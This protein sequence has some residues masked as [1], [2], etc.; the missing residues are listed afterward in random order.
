MAWC[1]PGEHLGDV[2]MKTDLSERLEA[3]QR[4]QRGELMALWRE[5]SGEEPRSGNVAWM[6]KRL[7]WAM[8]AAEYGGLSEAAE[9]RIEELL[10]QAIAWMPIGRATFPRQAAPVSVIERGRLKAGT[11]LTRPYKGKTI[12]VTVREDGF[13]YDGALHGSLS[14]VAKAVT[15]SHW[16][17]RLFFF[18]RERKDDA[19]TA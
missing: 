12:V 16:N 13:E 2:A 10:P 19:R 11:V 9:R 6:R 3:I 7:A 15:G 4:M 1:D 14:A 18:G 17:G 5:T 8:Q